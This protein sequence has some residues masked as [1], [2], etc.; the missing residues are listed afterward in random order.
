MLGMRDFNIMTVTRTSVPGGGFRNFWSVGAVFQGQLNI[1]T[2]TEAQLAFAQQGLE[3]GTL[4]V[5]KAYTFNLND[6]FFDPQNNKY[7]RVTNMGQQAPAETTGLQVI[8]YG[9]TWVR[10]LPQ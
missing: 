9:V 6:Y 5:N 4:Q 10:E 8:Q 2:S 3:L 7:Y 1:A